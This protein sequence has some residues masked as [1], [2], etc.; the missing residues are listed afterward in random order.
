MRCAVSDAMS[1]LVR[2][3]SS[4]ELPVRIP[5]W[6][7]GVGIAVCRVGGRSISMQ[8]YH[9]EESGSA[10][11]RRLVD[12]VGAELGGF[13][14]Y[15]A[16]KGIPAAD[17]GAAEDRRITQDLEQALRSMPRLIETVQDFA[18]NFAFALDEGLGLD[19]LSEQGRR[20]GEVAAKHEADQLPVGY[21]LFEKPDPDAA[22]IAGAMLKPLGAQ[23]VD[24]Y[25]GGDPNKHSRD[26]PPEPRVLVRDDSLRVAIP[27]AG[28][29]QNGALPPVLR[30]PAGALI[31]SGAGGKPVPAMVLRRGNF[32]YV[33]PEANSVSAP[34]SAPKSIAP[35]QSSGLWKWIA[36]GVAAV[37]VVAAIAGGVYFMLAKGE[38]PAAAPVEPVNKLRSNLFAPQ[39]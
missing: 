14:I 24:L 38:A 16:L 22:V 6:P 4:E 8:P 1:P 11:R 10:L 29:L 7:E 26:I 39:D 15:P 3:F 17:I 32:L 13:K 19:D 36:L 23:G 25:L 12:E 34:A 37:L 27:L 18:I 5:D 31:M 35:R 2:L 28:V 21:Q 30:L 33:A 9:M 20:K